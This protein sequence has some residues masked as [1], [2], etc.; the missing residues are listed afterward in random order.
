MTKSQPFCASLPN[1]NLCGLAVNG[2]S[3]LAATIVWRINRLNRTGSVVPR[4]ALELEAFNWTVLVYGLAWAA[5]TCR[6]PSH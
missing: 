3:N 4:Y 1:L 5:G 6:L 2:R